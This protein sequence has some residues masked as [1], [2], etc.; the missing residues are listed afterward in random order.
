MAIEAQLLPFLVIHTPLWKN[1]LFDNCDKCKCGETIWCG[2]SWVGCFCRVPQNGGSSFQQ[3]YLLHNE[4]RSWSRYFK[5]YSPHSI[6]IIKTVHWHGMWQ[7]T[8]QCIVSMV[9]RYLRTPNYVPMWYN[10]MVLTFQCV[11][12]WVIIVV[13]CGVNLSIYRVSGSS[14]QSLYPV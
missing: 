6:N 12:C 13:I 14:L 11:N 2:H 5:T 7:R 4:W 3:L 10:L 1:S 8:W 9:H